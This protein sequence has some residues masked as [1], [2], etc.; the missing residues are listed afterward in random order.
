MEKTALL[1]ALGA[2]NAESGKALPANVRSQIKQLEEDQKRRAKRAV[3]D[4]LDRAM[5]DLLSFYRDVLGAT[6]FTFEYSATFGQALSAARND[7][8]TAE[9]GKAIVFDYSY[10]YF[11]GDGYG[12]EFRILNLKEDSREK[13]TEML[14]LGNLLSFYEQQRI[15]QEQ[16]E[17]LRPY[18]LEKPL[19]V[20]VGSTVNAVYS[21]NKEKRSDVLTV[22]RFL[23]HVLENKRG[24][25][26]KGIDK[27][28]KGKSGLATPEGIDIFAGR[29]E[30]LRETGLASHA[31]YADILARLFRSSAS[32]GLH[33]CDIR[34]S[35][36]ELGLKAIGAEG[37]F[38]L[39][40]IGDTSEFKKLVENDKAGITLEE[41]VIA[42]SLFTD[43]NRPDS[44][45]NILIGAKKFMEGWNSWR[46]S[47][48]GLLNIGKKEG[49]EII[50]LFGRGVRLKGKDNSLKRSGYGNGADTPDYLP[51]PETLSIYGIEA[52]YLATFREFIGVGA[53]EPHLLKQGPG[54]LHCLL[55]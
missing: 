16:I 1:R 39:I 47:N 13:Q 14:L 52:E 40:Y 4:G 27:L 20:F 9:Y 55:L 28:L 44:K 8:L 45:V 6:G 5:T 10:R 50:Q 42:G 34:G 41:D 38:G 7:P 51:Y 49:P 30:A 53:F 36:G 35:A 23:H 25:V 33:L 2:D 24:W 11:Y 26:V 12:K 17:H 46:V 32:G 15:F 21:E 29:F 22:A 48:M 37:Y 31:L 54:P 18:N 43:I 3:V 19:W